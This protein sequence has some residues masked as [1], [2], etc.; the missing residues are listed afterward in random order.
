[1]H[2]GIEDLAVNYKS[3]NF[4]GALVVDSLLGCLKAWVVY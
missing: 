1:M 2:Y 3:L 4:I